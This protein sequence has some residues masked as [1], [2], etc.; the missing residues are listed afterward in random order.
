MIKKIFSILVLC[1][2]VLFA[3]SEAKG[4]FMALSIGPRVPVSGFAV[5]RNLGV[6]VDL[7]F[8]YTDITVLPVFIYSKIGFMHFPGKQDYYRTSDYSSISTNL[9]TFNPGIRLYLEPITKE[10]VLL[11]PVLDMGAAVTYSQTFHYFKVDTNKGSYAE[12]K[13][14]FGFHFGVGVSMFMLDAM[15]YYNYVPSAQYLAFD[16]SIRI[17][18]FASM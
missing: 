6:G 8:S 5:S 16:L 9:Y 14:N 10:I 12:N 7:G 13:F 4:L 2:S 1:S 15:A 11:M 18:I 3:Q 17:P